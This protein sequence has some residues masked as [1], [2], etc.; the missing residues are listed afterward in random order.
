VPEI[1][2]RGGR[3]AATQ[4]LRILK[5]IRDLRQFTE[6]Q[7][8]YL[9]KVMQQLEEGGLAKQTTKRTLQALEKEIKSNGTQPLRIL[10][11]LQKN[12]P[13]ELLESYI[14]EST[15]QTFGPREVILSEYFV[16]K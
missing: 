9:K 16:S 7:E 2:M 15:A 11:V 8:L 10:G 5:A 13:A 6:D 3:D 4:I 1:K 12:I 14:V